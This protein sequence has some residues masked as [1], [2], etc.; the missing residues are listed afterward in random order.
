MK[1]PL[2]LALILVTLS[3]SIERRLH[4]PGW[5]VEWKRHYSKNRDFAKVEQE[6]LISKKSIKSDVSNHSE[7]SELNSEMDSIGASPMLDDVNDSPISKAIQSSSPLKQNGIALDEKVR[8]K[9]S[10]TVE[11]QERVN[12]LGGLDFFVILIIL[13]CAILIA[14]GILA[15]IFGQHWVWLVLGVVLI[16]LGILL[17]LGFLITMGLGY[18]V[19]R[20]L[21]AYD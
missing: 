5:H 7:L 18:S 8:Q 14:G 15:I 11:K 6:N 16:V 2:L 1:Q 19:S 17:L 12:E 10:K 21:N 13:I 20:D 4:R 3:C 9:I